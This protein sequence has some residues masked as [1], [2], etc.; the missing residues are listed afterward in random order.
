MTRIALIA[1]LTVCAAPAFAQDDATSKA[2][3]CAFQ[4]EVVAA[5]QQARLD[6]VPEREVQAHILAQDPSW[7]ERFNTAIPLVT[8]WIYEEKR[9]DLRNK[10][11]SEAWIEGCLQQ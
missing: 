1:A 4:G 11:Y 5:V 2:E 10:D 9:R 3:S 6:R 7:P 8:P